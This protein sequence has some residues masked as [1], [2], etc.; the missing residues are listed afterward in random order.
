M[1]Q[2]TSR[3][4]FYVTVGMLLPLALALACR[5]VPGV[6]AITIV[7]AGFILSVATYAMLAAREGT[8]RATVAA[9][10]VMAGATWASIA[11][12][13]GISPLGFAI[14]AVGVATITMVMLAVPAGR[15]PVVTGPADPG[16]DLPPGRTRQEEE[17][18]A[19]IRR[20]AKVD[21]DVVEINEW[22]DPDNGF[23]IRVA[24]VEGMELKDLEPICGK[25]Q[26]SP[27][28]RLPQGC[29][30][31]L[32][33]SG[34]QCE[35]I[36]RVMT[37]DCLNDHVFLDMDTTPA[38]INDPFPLLRSPSGGWYKVCLRIFSMVIGGTTGS[39]KT[40][41]LDLIIAWLARCTD[42]LIWVVDFNGGGL[43][44]PWNRP[45]EEG[46]SPRPIVDWIGDNEAECAL[47][48]ACAK[49]IAKSRK[50]DRE[51]VSLRRKAGT[52]LL[53]LSPQ[54][55]GIV[56]I[57]DEGG[58]VRK[59]A[60]V[61]GQLVCSQ[62]SSVAQIGR[63]TGIRVVVSVLRGTADLLDKALRAVCSLR[64]CLRTDE[65]T[66]YTHVLGR[67]PGRTRLL[68]TGTAWIF[69][70][71]EDIKPGIGRSC[72]ITPAQVEAHAIACAG[73][74]PELDQAGQ[75]V[76]RSLSLRDVFS[77]R[78]PENYADLL[79]LPALVD[80]AD[81]NAYTRRH[82]RRLERL[83]RL[84]RGEDP[85]VVVSG[86]RKDDTGGNGHTRGAATDALLSQVEKRT[87]TE[88]TSGRHLLRSGE[89]QKPTDGDC[90]RLQQATTLRET[91]LSILSDIAPNGLRAGEI[92]ARLTRD[93]M[94]YSRG[95]LFEVLKRAIRD[96]EIVKDGDRYFRSSLE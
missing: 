88:L 5:T 71:T 40:T 59:A 27:Y 28:M 11:A 57:T 49:N 69:R 52:R 8:P 95:N 63:E 74:R 9:T 61:L 58:E 87:F 79:H 51:S 13:T 48:L 86:P 1:N 3:A 14:L 20:L 84:D 43:G 85:D 17:M 42:T 18:Q 6:P 45:Y 26:A 32:L 94:A 41:L 24:L 23:D 36:I 31:T 10:G 73:L 54:K 29:L 92:E 4:P 70:T 34:Y 72:D 38:S 75:A 80:V 83:E 33:D 91:L 46:R 56:V 90:K 93:G 50:T 81:G 44:A 89:D 15:G 12:A 62:I 19:L 7:I 25:L 37:R 67:N 66:E 77:G 22:D 21:L 65:E 82:Q 76:C 30:V 16:T 2:H 53:P 55:P 78:D 60:S 35:A 39:G 68:H 47:I 64:I 96:G